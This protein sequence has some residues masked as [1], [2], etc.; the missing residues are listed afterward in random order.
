A[1]KA[2]FLTPPGGA[3]IAAPS[4][5]LRPALDIGAPD[6][7]PATTPALVTTTLEGERV[8]VLRDGEPTPAPSAPEEPE[9]VRAAAAEVAAR[10][11]TIFQEQVPPEEE[12]ESQP[13]AGPEGD[14]RRP[15]ADF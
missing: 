15:Q 4:A 3:W 5:I 8:L 7:S 13:E 12:P 10:L 1:E 2:L 14:E 6:L 11:Q 9:P